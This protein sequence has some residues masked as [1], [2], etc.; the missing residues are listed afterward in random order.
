MI[1]GCHFH[2]CECQIISPKARDE[3][4]ARD[5]VKHDKLRELVEL[6][7]VREC[8]WT[9]QKREYLYMDFTVDDLFKLQ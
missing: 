1:Q 7:I 3:I 9:K 6:W 4:R 2:A 5:K 8:D